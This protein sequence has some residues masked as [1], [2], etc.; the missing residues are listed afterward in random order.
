MLVHLGI[1]E[2]CGLQSGGH[3]HW[4]GVRNG[5]MEGGLVV[6]ILRSGVLDVSIDLD[7]ESVD[8]SSRGNPGLTSIGG[9]IRNHDGVTICMFSS[10]LG[11]IISSSF[12]EVLAILKAY[13]LCEEESCPVVSRI[14]IESYSKSVVSW[15]SGDA[16]VGNGKMMD[17]ILDI[18]EIF[19]RNASKIQVQFALRSGNVSA[20]LLAKS[21]ALSGLVQM[22]WGGGGLPGPPFLSGFLSSCL[23]SFCGFLVVFAQLLFWCFCC[24]IVV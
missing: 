7:V 3:R 19:T 17:I 1:Q 20:D 4:Y 13:K 24:A 8:G 22:V 2:L 9:I 18:R 10:F 23:F 12:A 15:V 21:G 6:Q 14:I 16:G 5:D 11:D